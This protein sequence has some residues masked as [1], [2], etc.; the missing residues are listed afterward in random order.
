MLFEQSYD[1]FPIIKLS[2][3]TDYNWREDVCT[4][5]SHQIIL[6]VNRRLAYHDG[7]C[8]DPGDDIGVW[9]YYVQEKYNITATYKGT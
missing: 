5:K 8:S 9:E 2:K 6:V 4:P 7:Y 3:V 1:E